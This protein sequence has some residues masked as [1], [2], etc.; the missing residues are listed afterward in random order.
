M[1]I[2]DRPNTL[3]YN[4]LLRRP[5]NSLTEQEKLYMHKMYHYEEYLSEREEQE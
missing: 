3:L 2:Y 1:S 5:Y 4:E